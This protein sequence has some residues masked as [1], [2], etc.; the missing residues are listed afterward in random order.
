[1][2]DGQA[3]LKVRDYGTGIAP[4]VLDHFQT[5]GTK[6]GVGLAGMRERVHE[7]G[8]EFRIELCTPGTLILVTLPLADGTGQRAPERVA[9]DSIPQFGES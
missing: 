6:S 8:G 3:V 7:L 2:L 5:K 1:L 9:A 4:Q